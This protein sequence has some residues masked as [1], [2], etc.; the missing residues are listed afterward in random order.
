MTGKKVM[1]ERRRGS[2]VMKVEFVYQEKD[3]EGQMVWK[4]MAEEAITVD[5]G[6]E[7]SVCPLEWGNEFG[8][9]KVKPGM[10]MKMVNAAGGEMPHYGSRQVFFKATGF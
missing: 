6:A 10:E 1:L 8:L 7:E 9:S 2:Y 3:T 5:S 4:K